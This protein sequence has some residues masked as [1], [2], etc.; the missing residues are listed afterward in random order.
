MTTDHRILQT[1]QGIVSEMLG[2]ISKMSEQCDRGECPLKADLEA[3][4]QLIQTAGEDSG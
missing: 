3:L 4:L 2:T 1:V